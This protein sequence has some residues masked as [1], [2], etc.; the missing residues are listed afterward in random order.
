MAE[1]ENFAGDRTCGD[2][3]CAPYLACIKCGHAADHVRKR[4]LSL[5]NSG[6]LSTLWNLA[7]EISMAKSRL[8][9][10]TIRHKFKQ[11]AFS[12][13]VALNIVKANS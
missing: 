6:R 12:G 13:R 4:V 1:P 2:N 9:R 7:I 5:A 11:F 8:V 10:V 3:G